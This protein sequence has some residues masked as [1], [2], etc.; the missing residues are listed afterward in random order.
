M[1]S[2]FEVPL[3]TFSYKYVL[4]V[5]YGSGA[6]GLKLW[7]KHGGHKSKLNPPLGTR[8]RGDL[9]FPIHNPQFSILNPHY[10][11]SPQSEIHNRIKFIKPDLAV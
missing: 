5:W 9:A 3:I 2:G 6:P 4:N 8:G 10:S 7:E 1:C 11:I